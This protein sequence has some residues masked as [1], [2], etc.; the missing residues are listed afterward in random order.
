MPDTR[1]TKSA[2]QT[3]L[4]DNVAGDISPQDIRDLLVSTAPAYGAYYVSSAAATTLGGTSTP[5]KAAGTTASL[6]AS[7]DI[8]VATTNR[9]T[10][11]AAPTIQGLF[12]CAVTM[13]C[14]SSTQNV[15]LSVAKNGT[16]IAGSI[17]QRNIGTGSDK[18]AVATFGIVEL[19]QN[20]YLEIFVQ[21]DT[22]TGAIT[23]DKAIFGFLSILK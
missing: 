3:L 9:I 14:A 21:N 11:T 17:I 12:F 20:D 2:L 5:T 7:S 1:R 13:T 22:S 8:T 15:A 10:Y 4:A 16:Q 6:G 19:A 18:G 23:L